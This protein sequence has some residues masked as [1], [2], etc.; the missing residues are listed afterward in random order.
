[1]GI[2]V[3]CD[4]DK[5]TVSLSEFALSLGQRTK[6]METIG[7]GQWK[8]VHQTFREGGSPSGSWAPLSAASL[9]WQKYSAK[10]KLLIDS[11]RLLNSVGFEVRGN[12][13]VI[14]SGLS[15]AAVHQYGY[16]G[17]QNVRPYSYLRRQRSRDTFAREQIT[18]KLGKKQTVRRK[19]SSG[20]TTVNVKAFT[21]HIRIPARPFLVFRPE[22]PARI[23][24]EVEI[25]IA[26]VAKASGLGT[27]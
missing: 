1:M 25:F 12:S 6:L 23:Q 20:I 17:P 9:S 19:T 4:T 5:V 27:A 14:G 10:H 7:K 13:V 18:N 11:G 21:R 2:V 22:D 3:K 16:D 8:S 24:A 26:K 15:Y